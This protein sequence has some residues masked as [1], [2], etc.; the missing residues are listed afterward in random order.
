MNF[1]PFETARALTSDPAE[2]VAGIERPSIERLYSTF[3]TLMESSYQ[4]IQGVVKIEGT[5]PGP[6]LGVTV[7]THGNEPAGLA[8]AQFL[9]DTYVRDAR[10]FSGAISIVVN[11]PFATQA[12][13]E[14]MF[15]QDN[16]AAL[17]ARGIEINMNRIPAEA[18]LD[19]NDKRPEIARVRELQPIYDEFDVGVDIHSTLRPAPPMVVVPDQEVPE[20][21]LRGLPI[22]IVI[23]NISAVQ[24]GVPVSSLY[25][26]KKGAIR[27]V[28]EAGQHETPEAFQNAVI[29]LR[30]ILKNLGMVDSNE[31][32][33]TA[34]ERNDYEV[35][36]SVIFPDDSYHLARDFS[37]FEFIEKGTV[38]A[39]SEIEGEPDIVAQKDCHILFPKNPNDIST[40]EAM[41]LALKR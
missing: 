40:D 32:D 27:F 1:N 7:C 16:D 24:I 23:S 15:E 36:D 25:G 28:I 34:P 30:Q 13:F 9:I 6:T 20:N 33:F 5:H 29:S 11:N 37:N 22:G 41:F 39:M 17:K 4:G 21:L 31:V 12:Y 14:A 2:T 18:I 8:A 3:C 19:E 35:F 38:L 10:E 26:G